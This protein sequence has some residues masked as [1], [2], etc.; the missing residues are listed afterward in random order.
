MEREKIFTDNETGIK[1]NGVR[2][3]KMFSWRF[4]ASI[5]IKLELEQSRLYFRRR[6]IMAI[7]KESGKKLKTKQNTEIRVPHP[8]Y[9]FVVE[10]GTIGWEPLLGV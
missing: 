6:T 2:G 1:S 7:P 5:H 10:V 3:Q 4:L 8:W 9:C